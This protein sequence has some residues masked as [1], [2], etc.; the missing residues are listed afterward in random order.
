M[1]PKVLVCHSNHGSMVFRK[2]KH[3]G[4]PVQAIKRY[5]DVIFPEH[6]APGWSWGY[7]WTVNTPQGEV[8]FKHQKS[9]S[10]LADAAHNGRHLVVGH[11][12]G[13]FG[14]EYGASSQRLYWG[15]HTGCL[16]DKDALAFAYGKHSLKKPIIGC[17]VVLDGKPF[18]IPMLLNSRGRWVGYL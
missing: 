3:G 10:L 12:H 1:F 6:G 7:E 18:N 5:R 2:A 16:I 17:L 4:I 15:A 8:L 9:G 11:E 14:A 13:L